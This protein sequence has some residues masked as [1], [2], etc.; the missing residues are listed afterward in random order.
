M[1]R[2]FRKYFITIVGAL[3][4][5]IPSIIIALNYLLISKLLDLKSF[6]LFVPLI[7]IY[8]G[9]IIGIFLVRIHD[10]DSI[11]NQN[12][13]LQNNLLGKSMSYF[14]LVIA[15]LGLIYLI[16]F[17]ILNLGVVEENLKYFF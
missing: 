13:S 1:Y 8:I 16:L 2:Y 9:A 17:L 14:W 10:V 7:L 3:F 11:Q 4:V 5:T 15:F 6:I 12:P